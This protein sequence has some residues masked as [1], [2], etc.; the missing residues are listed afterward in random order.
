MVLCSVLV[1]GKPTAAE[2]ELAEPLLADALVAQ[3]NNVDLL[4]AAAGV[5]VL[6]Q[7]NSDAIELYRRINAIQP[8]NVLALNNLASLLGE[9]PQTR[10]EAIR[11][12]DQAIDAA[13]RLPALLDTKGTIL[14]YD[15]RAEDA[16]TLLREATAGTDVD[17][18][19]YFHL[20]L[21]C[22]GTGKSDEA[23][24]AMKKA[25]EGNLMQFILTPLERRLLQELEQKLG[26]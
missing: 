7:R 15:G 13:G 2:F 9:E 4:G 5:R 8:Q 22:M 20:S 19:Y 16:A 14:V 17:P 23:R 24:A 11:F 12:I 26:P 3:P 25:R 18:R 1:A 21:A 10:K 6:Q